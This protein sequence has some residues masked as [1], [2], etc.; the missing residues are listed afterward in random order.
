MKMP[1]V[2][3]K[4]PKKLLAMLSDVYKGRD[5]SCNLMSERMDSANDL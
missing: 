4:Q 2:I 1:T 5:R 3:G